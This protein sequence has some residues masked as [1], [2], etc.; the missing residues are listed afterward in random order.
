MIGGGYQVVASG[1]CA[2]G[3]GQ[4]FRQVSD[5]YQDGGIEES[6]V[7]VI[8]HPGT[9]ANEGSR[10]VVACQIS[11]TRS[12]ATHGPIGRWPYMFARA[13]DPRP[14][15][16]GAGR[17]GMN[18]RRARSCGGGDSRRSVAPDAEMRSVPS[19]GGRRPPM[20]P[21]LAHGTQGRAQIVLA[22][23]A[24]VGPCI[25]PAVSA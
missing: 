13:H 15:R 25:W 19:Q 20:L 23:P 7:V 5:G 10:C 4:V 9:L 1:R 6:C 8:G 3:S 16:R 12:R 21:M 14:L 2:A 24:R 22:G 17:W 11:V 18:R